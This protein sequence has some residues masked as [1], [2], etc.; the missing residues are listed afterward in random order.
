MPTHLRT[1]P[2]SIKKAC[3]KLQALQGDVME[4]IDG[5]K[6]TKEQASS[7]R[8]QFALTTLH[9]VSDQTDAVCAVVVAHKYESANTNLRTILEA[10]VKLEY[11]LLGNKDERVAALQYRDAK[12]IE[13]DYKLVRKEF[14]RHD[15]NWPA[16][17]KMYTDDFA[18]TLSD[19]LSELK[20]AKE[21]NLEYLEEKK[22]KEFCVNGGV[23]KDTIDRELVLEKIV[24]KVDDEKQALGV[25]ANA[26]VN[27]SM[28]YGLLSRTVHVNSLDLAQKYKFDGKIFN[29]GAK[30]E[31]ENEENSLR[32]IM[33]AYGGLLDTF[34]ETLKELGREYEELQKKHI[35]IMHSIY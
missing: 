4:M 26:R 9:V 16:E 13:K 15:V 24:K 14:R 29:V 1:L 27:N 17:N 12:H 30:T 20:A 7:A 19:R 18:N 21:K 25:N 35:T 28:V 33:T 5:G 34:I 10:E 22:P 31:Q 3:A 23:D 8:V 11:A 2:E 32:S 6:M